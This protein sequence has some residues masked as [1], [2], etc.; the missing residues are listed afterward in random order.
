MEQV[1][2]VVKHLVLAKFKDEVT[3]E[4]IEKH[5]KDYANLLNH[6]EHLKSFQ[7]G[8]DV[9]IENLHQGFTHIFECTFEN[10]EGRSAFVC[11]PAHVDFATAFL[12]ILEKV[13]LVDFVPTVVKL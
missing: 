2:G 10:L 1:Q 13:V 9:S 12:R 4:E 5:I 7:W 8:T 11:H 3:E 6:I